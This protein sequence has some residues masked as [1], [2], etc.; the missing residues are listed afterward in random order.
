M[1]YGLL[2]II[3]ALF[4]KNKVIEIYYYCRNFRNFFVVGRVANQLK[5]LYIAVLSE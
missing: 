1:A 4:M 5:F 2:Q 3:I